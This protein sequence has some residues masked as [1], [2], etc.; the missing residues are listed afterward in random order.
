MTTWSAKREEQHTT[1]RREIPTFKVRTAVPPQMRMG[2]VRR[3][4]DVNARLSNMANQTVGGPNAGAQAEWKITELS[5]PDE[6]GELPDAKRR[7]ST[8]AVTNKI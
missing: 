4:G 2:L 5:T 7:T 1:N 3:G 6:A 8:K